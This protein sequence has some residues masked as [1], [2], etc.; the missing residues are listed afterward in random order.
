MQQ[1]LLLLILFGL[2]QQSLNGGGL[3]AILL[4]LLFDDASELEHLGLRRLNLLQDFAR[5]ARDQLE[6]LLGS[7]E[8]LAKFFATLYKLRSNDLLL[9]QL[10]LQCIGSSSSYCRTLLQESNVLLQCV[11]TLCETLKFQ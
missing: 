6:L 8:L 11:G 10:G 3:E 5:V 1:P 7:G 2:L 4:L 9:A